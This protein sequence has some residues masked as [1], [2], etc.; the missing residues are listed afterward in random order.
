MLRELNVVLDI[1]ETLFH[2][3]NDPRNYIPENPYCLELNVFDG[4][5]EELILYGVLRPFVYDFLRYVTT[6]CAKVIIWSAGQRNYVY[7]IVEAMFRDIGWPDAILTYDN[8]EIDQY[9]GSYDKSIEFMTSQGDGNYALLGVNLYNTLVIDDRRDN[10]LPNMDNGLLV[11][12]FQPFDIP[13]GLKSKDK[14]L[15]EI[16][17]WMEDINRRYTRLK[18]IRKIPKPLFGEIMPK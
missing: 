6:K 10:F 9:S 13:H 2:V 3:T 12:R 16:E 7:S 14:V 11:P 17:M 18:D 4:Y 1:D 15:K 5:G 8:I